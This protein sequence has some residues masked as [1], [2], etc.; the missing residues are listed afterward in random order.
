MPGNHGKYFK[1]KLHRARK[2]LFKPA[3]LKR[4]DVQ[5]AAGP[6]LRA[7]ITGEKP[8]VVYC[9]EKAAVPEAAFRRMGEV[10]EDDFSGLFPSGAQVLIKINL[11]TADPYP[12]STSPEMAGALVDFL[13]EKGITD[14]TVADC[15]GNH[16]LPTI[17]TA[18]RNGIMKALKGKARFSFFDGG[19]WSEVSLEGTFLGKVTVPRSALEAG[20]IIN[21]ANLKTHCHADFSFGLKLAVGFMHP[22]E[23]YSLHR[24]N[25]REKIA[26]INLAVPADLTI[27]DGRTAFITGG[28]DRGD[29]A[30][31]DVILF[32]K[33]PL[34]VDIQ[35]Y[36][37]LYAMK[38]SRG[39]L[40][41]FHEDPF[42]MAQLRRAREIGIGG[43]PWNGYILEKI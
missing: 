6:R 7:Q 20:R 35:A 21:L 22:L 31:G 19:P 14:I 3:V 27:I 36:R 25:L 40:E 13:R 15:S 39:C 23:R 26:E 11:N 16:S 24:K 9:A 41:K 28:P 12:G 18:R 17:R 29:E 1:R 37:A 4:K 42:Q 5:G 43:I 33:N 32:G 10:W 30:R 2:F 34:A 8:A 38:Q